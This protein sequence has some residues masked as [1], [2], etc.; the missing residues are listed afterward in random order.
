[1]M[2]AV[3]KRVKDITN[4]QFGYLT[5]LQFVSSNRQGSRWL[6]SCKCGNTL[7]ARSNTVAYESKKGKPNFPSCGCQELAQKTKHG[8]RKAKDTHPL[9][10]VLKGMKER[11]YLQT[12]PVFK[13]YG[14]VGVT[15]CQEWLDDPKAF[16]E[17]GLVNGWSKGMHIDKDILCEKLGIRPHVYSPE[18]CQFVTAKENVGFATNRDNFGKHP[19]VKLSHAQVAEILRLY[20]SGEQT[21]MSQLARDYK[22]HNSSIQ[23]LI[24]LEKKR[25]LRVTS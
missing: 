14:A 5:A 23:R 11:C 18:T 10:S 20:F 19:N 17:W 4:Q 1:M 16:I 22:V 12:C 8:Y 6:Y 9:Y 15:V 7:E 2:N 25:G 21:S 24:S 13:W 3:P